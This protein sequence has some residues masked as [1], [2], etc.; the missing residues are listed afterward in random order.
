MVDYIFGFAVVHVSDLDTL[1]ILLLGQTP[2]SLFDTTA[3]PEYLSTAI[4]QIRDLSLTLKLP[5]ATF[6]EIVQFQNQT[7]S[8]SMPTKPSP[9]SSENS[10]S[11]SWLHLVPAIITTLPLIR[12]LSI[13]LDHTSSRS[14]SHVNERE[15]LA[16]L[17]TFIASAPGVQVEVNLPHLNPKYSTLSRHFVPVYSPAPS[18]T[19]TR[20]PRQRSYI[21]ITSGRTVTR[22]YRSPAGWWTCG[23]FDRNEYHPNEDNDSSF[24]D[25]VDRGEDLTHTFERGWGWWDTESE[26]DESDEAR[27]PEEIGVRYVSSSSEWDGGEEHSSEWGGLEEENA[28]EESAGEESEEKRG[29]GMEELRE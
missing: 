3:V 12:T 28:G 24:E 10:P 11:S 2:T 5:L 25:H 27:G 21:L 9:P 26:E 1:G 13:W 18:Y 4:I 17:D 8:S 16:P 20:R 23:S 14:W 6:Q 19:I 15:F 29:F 22:W 7:Q